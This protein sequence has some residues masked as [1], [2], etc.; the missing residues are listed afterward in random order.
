M[1]L[2]HPVKKI[3]FI[4]PPLLIETVEFYPDFPTPPLGIS[5]I[6]ANAGENLEKRILDLTFTESWAEVVEELSG[7]PDYDLY[8]FTSMTTN[9][10][11][12]MKIAKYLKEK[13]TGI[14]V[15]GGSHATIFPEQIV[16]IGLFDIAVIGEG[17]VT[18]RELIERL[19]RQEPL[20]LIAGISFKDER[21]K[22]VVASKREKIADLDQLN[23][24]DRHLLPMDKYIHSF[25]QTINGER[26]TTILCSRG[27]PFDCTFCSKE[28]F[29][30][31]I[32]WRR[33]ENIIQ[34]IEFLVQT[35]QI[36]TIHFVDDMFAVNKPFVNKIT[37]LMQERMPGLQWRCE[38]RVDS[39]D[40]EMLQDMKKA[41]CAGIWFGVESGDQR[42]LDG[43]NKR[44]TVQQA[45]EA[46]QI[47]KAAG[48]VVGIF[49]I[50]GYPGETKESL[51][52]TIRIVER[53]KPNLISVSF[54]TI[55][56]GTNFAAQYFKDCKVT[57]QFNDY[58][59]GTNINLTHI[60]FDDLL[61]A[62]E[63][64]F[65]IVRENN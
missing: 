6:S 27:C 4:I 13:K 25:G 44:T 60:T 42:I 65:E 32:K 15:I 37:G 18:F 8:A 40:R 11:N 36:D 3:L 14:F 49:I 46:C 7:L 10:S 20:E 41:N 52:N 2:T 31:K 35:Y 9:F 33:P 30:R 19:N 53:I 5:Y 58:H 23:F 47:A 48:I 39:L 29:G 55:L 50:L 56:P 59:I 57:S 45:L 16:D 61:Q 1:K 64:I 51:E 26:G 12:T 38:S 62:R 17:E 24:P 43:M 21:G 28:I 63:T 54:S 34:E 22:V